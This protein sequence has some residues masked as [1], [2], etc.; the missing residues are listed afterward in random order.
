[1]T[2][3][4]PKAKPSK[5][6]KRQP[7]QPVA[8]N[9]S[10]DS[11]GNA[12]HARGLLE[13]SIGRQLTQAELRAP[14]DAAAARASRA[15]TTILGELEA[16]GSLGEGIL[17]SFGIFLA[18]VAESGHRPRSVRSQLEARWQPEPWG[19]G[20]PRR[21]DGRPWTMRDRALFLLVLEPSEGGFADALARALEAGKKARKRTRTKPMTREQLAALRDR[22]APLLRATE[23][24]ERKRAENQRIAAE[25]EA[26]R[27]A[28]DPGWRDREW[29]AEREAQHAWEVEH[30]NDPP[31]TPH[32]ALQQL[33]EHRARGG[34]RPR[35]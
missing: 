7:R 4:A 2:K 33:V 32:D 13:A 26:E 11:K 24:L 22:L 6:S 14:D 3:K 18:D 21:A 31:F 19:Q 10:I 23:V 1:M 16:L 35:R 20:A 28:V 34:T 12:K 25:Y 27:D 17:A 5:A 30:A 29:E 8:S 9:E 15:A